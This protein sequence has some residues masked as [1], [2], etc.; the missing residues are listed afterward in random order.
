[1]PPIQPIP[2]IT[3]ATKNGADVSPRIAPPYDVLNEASKQSLL[4]TDPHNIVAIDLPH[5][6]AK[7]VGPDATYEQAG[8]QFRQW[9]KEGVLTH[10]PEPAYFVYQQTFTAP[11]HPSLK[12]GAAMSRRGLFVNMRIQPFGQSS[13]GQGAVHPHEQTFSGPKEDRMKLMCATRAQL[14]PIFGLY[15]DPDDRVGPLLEAVIKGGP[16]DQKGQT[17]YDG[18]RHEAWA[19]TDAAAVSR[20]SEALGHTDVFIADGHHRYTTAL[21]Y[22]Q[23][24]IDAGQLAP[25]NTGA[26][27]AD[28]CLTVLVSMQDP[29]MIVLPTHRVLG[30]MES[31]S[32]DRLSQVAPDTLKVTPFTGKDLDALEAALPLAGPHAMGL[33]DPD[34]P[35]GPMA[36]AT[37]AQQDPLGPSHAQQSDAW[38]QLDVAIL[39]HLIVEQ[40]CQP[41][42]CA[43][44]Q[45]I[46]WKFPHTLAD[47]KNETR[48][49]QFQ[50]GVIMQPPP[51]SAIRQISENGELMPPKSTFFYPKIATGLVINPIE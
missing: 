35:G 40:I 7:T 9:L 45:Q 50:L 2:A 39:Q 16:P 23:K 44:G 26:H 32:L 4:D 41:H 6:P 29:G 33:Y 19:V 30:N 5:L 51:L 37:T 20:L 47:L 15:T 24:L 1:M 12:P 34:N 13:H 31:F 43:A 17:P 42:F 21:N 38:R 11:G 28:H 18:V 25:N 49:Q 10:R 8:D 36:I 3:Y 48:T 46:A 22:R 14:S 27:R